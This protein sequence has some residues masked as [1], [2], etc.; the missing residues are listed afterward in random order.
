VIA[1]NGTGQTA[2]VSGGGLTWTLLERA[3]AQPGDTE[4]W[5]ARA[6]AAL[7]NAVISASFA[8]QANAGFLNVYAFTN[9]AGIGAHGAA[10]GSGTQPAVTL[11]NLTAGSIV[12]ATGSNATS[13][14]QP[15]PYSGYVSHI[16]QDTTN[17]AAYWTQQES[18]VTATTGGQIIEGDSAPTGQQWN[19]AAFEVIPGPTIAST[20]NHYGNGSDSPRWMTNPNGSVT[21]N[22]AGLDGNLGAQ[23]TIGGGTSPV[24]IELADLHGDIA[25]TADV[26][27]TGIASTYTY[28]EYGNPA[29]T[30]TLTYGWLGAKTRAQTGTTNLTL[31]GVRLYNPTTGRFLQTDPVP[32]GSANPY[33]YCNADPV[34]CNDLNGTHP[35]DPTIEQ[36]YYLV[37]YQYGD[38]GA[39]KQPR[40]GQCESSWDGVQWR[41]Q[42]PGHWVSFGHYVEPPLPGYF[43]PFED[44]VS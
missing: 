10:S 2:T 26:G 36:G 5:T 34:N 22:I 18:A 9:A 31:M 20:T 21:R 41:L 28:D 13:S 25:A 32:G 15:S 16:T 1:M 35:I 42:H 29:T 4:I 38:F 7:A 30:N 3:N 14:A 19:F 24:T 27:S 40:N 39:C 43:S 12:R 11:A 17:G 33:D 44:I 6:P 23:V 8:Q 37:I